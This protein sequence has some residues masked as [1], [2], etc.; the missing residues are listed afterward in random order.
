MLQKL[1]HS[2]LIA[3]ITGNYHMNLTEIKHCIKE[4]SQ[5]I[6]FRKKITGMSKMVGFVQNASPQ[7]G[8]Y[9]NIKPMETQ[10]W[11]TY[12]SK[13]SLTE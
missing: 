1:V 4:Q 12:Q 11:S 13:L 10:M 6:F 8:K 9:H 3:H 2:R 7:S 5:R